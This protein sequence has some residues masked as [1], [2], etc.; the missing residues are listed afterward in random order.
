MT[1]NRP[2][3]MQLHTLSN[4][5]ADRSAHCVRRGFTLIELL[6]AVGVI[7]VLIALL[8]PA[9]LMA[10]RAAYQAQCA[11][12]LRQWALALNTYV[13]DYHGWLPRRG[14]GKMPTQTVIWPDDWFNAL[15][16]QL[17][18][19]SY[20]D[21]AASAQI[22]GLGGSRGIWVCPESTAK[23]NPNGYF[24]SYAMNMALSVRNAAQPDRMNHVGSTSTMVFMADAPGAFCSTLP[25]ISTPLQPAPFNPSPRHSGR[26]NLSFLDGHVTAYAADEIGCN[27]GDPKRQD[28]RWFWYM[29]GPYPAPWTG[30]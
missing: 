12:N 16:M 2:N 10:R 11:S 4:P 18:Q 1:G 8:M 7:S 9:L 20:S 27:T 28:V 22:P 26:V 6:V 5:F 21:L 30:P 24:F 15:P 19:K 3:L 25:F 23:P 13:N 17:G 14:Q 29:P